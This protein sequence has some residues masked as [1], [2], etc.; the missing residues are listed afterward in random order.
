MATVLTFEDDVLKLLFWGNA[1][2]AGTVNI[3]QNHV[4]TPATQYFVALLRGDPSTA[5]APDQTTQE[6]TYSGYARIAVARTNLGWN[7]AN[8]LVSPVGVLVFGTASAVATQILATHFGV[9]TLVSGAGKLIAC[10]KLVPPI[11]IN[12][13]T[14]PRIDN[15]PVASRMPDDW[16]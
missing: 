6:V 14:T 9:G 12:T 8:G 16:I 2:T 3:A 5:I 10:G 11:A 4:T 7:V 13:G 15:N 1:I